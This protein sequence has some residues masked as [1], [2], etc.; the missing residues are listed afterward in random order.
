MSRTLL[1]AFTLWKRE[2][3]RFVRQRNR[4]TSAI[5]QPAVFWLLF[6]TGFQGAFSIGGGDDKQGFLEFLFPGT[7]VMV[8]LFTA[9]FSTF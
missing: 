1:P 4:L 7:V 8:L 9:I 2:L 5:V 6:G 3:V